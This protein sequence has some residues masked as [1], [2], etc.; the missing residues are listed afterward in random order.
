M[1]S[2]LSRSTPPHRT[3]V[4][5]G[6]GHT[7]NT[8]TPT[9]QKPDIRKQ[10]AADDSPSRTEFALV[11]WAV[12]RKLSENYFPRAWYD[13]VPDAAA[14]SVLQ[15]RARTGFGVIS[16]L[17][18]C[19]SGRVSRKISGSHLLTSAGE[20]SSGVAMP[21][22]GATSTFARCGRPLLQRGGEQTRIRRVYRID[23]MRFVD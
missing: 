21:K 23:A 14:R 10:K 12:G 20:I 6:D 4:V 1:S 17:L 8:T 7:V 18:F 11:D 9:P 5:S 2:T 3:S 16:F 13:L 22:R 15:S 19:R